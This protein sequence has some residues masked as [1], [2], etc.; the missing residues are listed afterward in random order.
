MPSRGGKQ[1]DSAAPEADRGPAMAMS[2]WQRRLAMFSMCLALFLS[3]LDITIVAT[4]LPTIARALGASAAEYAWIGSSY[5]LAATSSNPV[6]AKLSDVFGRKSVLMLSNGVF[7]AGS[8]VAAMARSPSMLIGGRVVQGLG[9]G[10]SLVLVTIIIGDMFELKDRAK[11]YSFIGMVWAVASCVGPILGGVFTERI[12]WRWCF[13]INLPFDGASIIVLFFALNVKWT[14]VPVAEALRSLDWIGCI[15]IV[16]GTICFLYGLE[17]ASSGLREWDSAFVLCLLI[18]GILLLVLFFF[19]EAYF[20]K[21]PLIPV[22]I[23]RSFTNIASF[24]TVCLH[25]LIFINCDYF[26]PLY[27]QVVLGFTP[28]IS[29]VTL[30]AMVI[31]LSIFSGG[32]GLFIK[33]TGNYLLPIWFGAVMMT[34]GTGLFIS[35]DATTNW[36]KI[37]VFLIIAGIGS[38]PLFQSPLIALQ[39]HVEPGDVAMASSALAFAR[40]LFTSISIVVGT[41]LLQ[42]T[43]GGANLTANTASTNAAGSGVPS[44]TYKYISALRVMWKFYTA[45]GGLLIIMTCFIKKKDL[46]GTNKGVAGPDNEEGS[47][48][49]A[50]NLGKREDATPAR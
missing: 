26:L 47:A 11:Y 49:T 1:V 7:M 43:L 38:G 50:Q 8:L 33:K 41:V 45:A 34:L 48:I 29:G 9:S 42:R 12:G 25:S 46:L 17:T 36:A 3:A 23:F 5:T 31:P 20:A 16:G 35:F 32:S 27:F 39:S 21:N 14:R 44:M 19:Y 24:S 6:W 30:F 40:N 10:G 18:F 37:I 2:A 22:R 15:A 28:I 4:A 13:W